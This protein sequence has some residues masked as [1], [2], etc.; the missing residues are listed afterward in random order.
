MFFVLL[1][2]EDMFAPPDD[3]LVISGGLYNCTQMSPGDVMADHTFPVQPAHMRLEF[4]NDAMERTP[5]NQASTFQTQ[6]V[7]S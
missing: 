2:T 7:Q 3:T 6:R 5:G 4:L 1:R